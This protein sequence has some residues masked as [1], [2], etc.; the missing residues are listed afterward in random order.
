MHRL[1]AHAQHLGSRGARTEVFSERTQHGRRR[2]ENSNRLSLRVFLQTGTQDVSSSPNTRPANRANLSIPAPVLPRGVH[3]Q[4]GLQ[5]I[6]GD[7]PALLS[8][9]PLSSGQPLSRYTEMMDKAWGEQFRQS[10][11]AYQLAWK[12]LQKRDKKKTRASRMAASF[13]SSPQSGAGTAAAAAAAAARRRHFRP[14][15]LS[16]HRTRLSL[17]CVQ[18]GEL[19]PN[20]L[21]SGLANAARGA[22]A[23]GIS[24]ASMDVATDMPLA[25][26]VSEAS[27]LSESSGA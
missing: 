16:N 11:S 14:I 25:T 19:A 21:A 5:E 24:F 26:T 20:S 18:D 22:A 10:Q 23:R 2:A 7:T 12:K 27:R 8:S 6:C 1:A 4:I 9:W 3:S 15:G 13:E 17:G